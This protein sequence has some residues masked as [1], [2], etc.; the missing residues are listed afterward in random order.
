MD[1]FFQREEVKKLLINTN[2]KG[3]SKISCE[4]YFLVNLFGSAATKINNNKKK[5]QKTNKQKK[6]KKQTKK[7][8]WRKLSQRKKEKNRR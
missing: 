3:K 5:K 2:A 7:R 4:I 1:S 8:G 6:P